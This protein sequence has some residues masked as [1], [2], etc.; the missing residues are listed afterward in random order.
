MSMVHKLLTG[1]VYLTRAE[2]EKLLQEK[3]S[4]PWNT[5]P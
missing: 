2:A 3:E 5:D 1:E 4:Q